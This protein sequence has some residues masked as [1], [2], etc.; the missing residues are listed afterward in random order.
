MQYRTSVVC[1][2]R[3]AQ[4]LRLIRHRRGFTAYSL[5]PGEQWILMLNADA[6]VDATSIR[7]ARELVLALRG[8]PPLNTVLDAST[9][10]EQALYKY[11]GPDL[12]YESK[13]VSGT[14]A[15]REMRPDGV[16]HGTVNLLFS[17][18]TIDKAGAGEAVLSVE[19]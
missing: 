6:K 7:L 1:K 19:F 9:W 11:G 5:E 13:T 3:R 12:Q 4:A 17:S 15:I 10:I 14:L 8:A 16:C 18:P 2:Y